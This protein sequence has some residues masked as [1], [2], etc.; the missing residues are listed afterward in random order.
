MHLRHIVVL[1]SAIAIVASCGPTPARTSAPTAA[2]TSSPVPSHAPAQSPVDA[3]SVR[4]VVAGAISL[5]IPGPWHDRQPGLN[6][7]GNETFLFAGP[8]DLP[9]ECAP[10]AQGT[11]CAAWPV[12]HLRP[13]ELVVAVRFYG[14][15]GFKPPVGGL[16]VTVGVLG[17]RRVEGT[18]DGA[19]RSID[20]TRLVEVWL[21][22]FA[23]SNGFYSIDAC[24]SGDGAAAANTFAAILASVGVT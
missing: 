8:T 24:I 12:M 9:S 14:Q 10:T 1:A 15:P 17:A 6:P 2:P 22:A 5:D 19:C 20:G 11:A 18:A 23:G 21:P 7:S 3:T 16:P 13:D 4:R